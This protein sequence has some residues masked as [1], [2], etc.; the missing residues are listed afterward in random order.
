MGVLYDLL[1]AHMVRPVIF[2]FFK[3]RLNI[4]GFTILIY[5]NPLLKG[6]NFIVKFISLLFK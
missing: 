1:H 6:I 5:T 4:K 2:D 3:T